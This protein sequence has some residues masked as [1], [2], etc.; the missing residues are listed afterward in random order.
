MDRRQFLTRSGGGAAALAVGGVLGVS[1]TSTWDRSH[2]RTRRE[3]QDYASNGRGAQRVWWSLETTEPV[4]AITF[5]DGPHPELT[6]RVLAVL[7]DRSITATFFMIGRHVH[8]HP[9]L[10]RRVLAAGHEVANHSW[11]HRRV[12]DEDGGEL[13]AEIVDGALALE[14]LTGAR[15]RWFRPPRGM[16]TGELLMAAADVG[17]EVVL[18]SVTRGGPEV[19]D[20]QAVLHHLTSHLHPGAIIDLHDGTGIDPGEPQL[21]RRRHQEL[22]VLPA[23]LDHAVAHHY[24]FVTVS[25]LLAGAG[26]PPPARTDH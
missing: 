22:E 10:A 19:S 9:G 11:S 2:E 20:A 24:R 18:W 7:A 13:K 17:E 16:V 3:V 5:D 4:V 6:P 21:L 25:E 14:H 23:F 26:G 12:V 15:P 1:A 8:D